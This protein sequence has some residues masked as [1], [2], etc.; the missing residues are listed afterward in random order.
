MRPGLLSKPAEQ[1]AAAE[2]IAGEEIMALIE[3]DCNYSEI[4][5]GL[6]YGIAYTEGVDPNIA[7]GAPDNSAY[8]TFWISM[9]GVYGQRFGLLALA[10]PYS[11]KVRRAEE[12]AL[13]SSIEAA[14]LNE[15]P[16]KKRDLKYYLERQRYYLKMFQ[17]GHSAA[18][19]SVCC[20]AF[21]R[22]ESV[23]LRL[24]NVLRYGFTD[25][26][27]R[28]VIPEARKDAELEQSILQ[29]GLIQERSDTPTPGAYREYPFLTPL[30]SQALTTYFPICAE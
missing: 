1:I 30:T 6:P 22:E 21:C 26:N 10:K 13:I 5:T 28:I 11:E 29:F 27:K 2:L 18:L 16:A 7:E 4:L 24:T 14:S 12:L 20:Y 19:W 25:P 9:A 17:Q 23:A 15:D 3:A 8:G